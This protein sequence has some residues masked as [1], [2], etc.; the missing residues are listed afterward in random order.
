MDEGEEKIEDER[1]VAELQKI[2]R[3]INTRALIAAI[4]VTLV[5]LAFPG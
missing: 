2:A 4:V 1:A 3:S 5:A